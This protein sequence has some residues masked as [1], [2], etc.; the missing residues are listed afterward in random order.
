MFKLLAILALFIP[1]AIQS[2]DT[3]DVPPFC[4]VTYNDYDE[5]NGLRCETSLA[6]IFTEA[7][8]DSLFS[9]FG[10]I[11][12]DGTQVQRY[13]VNFRIEETIHQIFHRMHY[14]YIYGVL[15]QAAV[16]NTGFRELIKKLREV[17]VLLRPK[18]LSEL[19]GQEHKVSGRLIP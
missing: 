19:W 3:Q 7:E 2:Q 14:N 11:V 1:I 18:T 15:P 8:L 9:M 4:Q 6:D 17:Q 10:Q 16:N 5:P 12:Q 13:K